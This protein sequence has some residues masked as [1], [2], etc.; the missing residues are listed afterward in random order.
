MAQTPDQQI[1]TMIADMPE[2]TGKTLD[3]WLLV[4]RTS[5]GAKHGEHMKL[6]KE[7]HGVSHG[8][9]N[10][11]AEIHMK[12]RDIGRGNEGD[13]L[14]SAQYAGPKS[15][16]KPIYD[17]LRA[18]LE[19]LGRDI[20]FAPKKAYVSVRR[21]KQF[22][23]I[24]PSTKTRLDLGLQLKGKDP[25]GALEL[26]GSWNTM[27]SHRVRL[28]RLEYVTEEVKALLEEAYKNAK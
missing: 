10:L 15:A 2:K 21:S 4:L 22:A 25:E 9:A 26:A 28:A 3:E 8:F 16:L 7:T 23:L 20:E 11:I 6:L 17:A 13:D 18:G 1:E 5:E 14:I 12:G 19:S 27:V 24:Q